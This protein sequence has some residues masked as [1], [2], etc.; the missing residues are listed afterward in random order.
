[1][2]NTQSTT[3]KKKRG[4]AVKFAAVAGSMALATTVAGAQYSYQN[5]LA[6]TEDMNARLS[7]CFMNLFPTYYYDKGPNYWDSSEEKVGCIGVGMSPMPQTVDKYIHEM[8]ELCTEKGDF[9]IYY[10]QKDYCQVLKVEPWKMVEAFERCK[11]SAKD[12]EIK[13][14]RPGSWDCATVRL[15][16]DPTIHLFDI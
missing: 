12:Q 2:S 7:S 9:V 4:L 10:P 3:G 14:F 15:R 1:M 8:A 5:H 11:A 6:E 13:F 16:P